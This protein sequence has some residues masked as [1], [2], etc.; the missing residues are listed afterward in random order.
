MAQIIF[1]RKRIMKKLLAIALAVIMVLGVFAGCQGTNYQEI[2][3]ADVV[4]HKSYDS[5]YDM[6]GSKITIDMVEENNGLAYV[7]YEGVKYELGM[8]FLS[9]AMVYNCAPA[10]EYE[11]AEEVYNN[12]ISGVSDRTSSVVLQHDI[13]GFSVDAVE[14]IL[15]WGICNGY[16]FQPL[17]FDSP[18]YHHG[19]RN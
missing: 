11:T 19:I 6:I 1:R 16:S 14:K 8:D 7:T 4:E 2:D 17:T 3:L 5:V 15:V 10:G 13:K 18:T 12:V 9:M